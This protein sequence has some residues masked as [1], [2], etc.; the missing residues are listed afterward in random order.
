MLSRGHAADHLADD[1]VR[2]G[3]ELISE[4]LGISLGYH[5]TREAPQ[6]AR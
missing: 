5:G 3:N 4:L 1:P 2:A 6:L